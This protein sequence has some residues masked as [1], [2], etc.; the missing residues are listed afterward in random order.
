MSVLRRSAAACL[1][2][3]C[4]GFGTVAA[5]AA[6][7]APTPRATCTTD[8]PAAMRHVVRDYYRD[9]NTGAWKSLQAV[10]SDDHRQHLLGPLPASG[11]DDSVAAWKLMKTVF[12][13]LKVNART[14]TA[15]RRTASSMAAHRRP[16]VAT[17]GDI[18]LTDS[19]GP[20]KIEFANI[21]F[22]DRCDHIVDESWV[23]TTPPSV[24]ADIEAHLTSTG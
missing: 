4:L 9:V 2:I 1:G 19:T 13:D 15:D 14:L 16:S 22:F 18:T 23:I 24:V 7:A 5:P 12:P 10:L 17:Y 3:A 6:Q 21:V 11:S 8:S 20:K